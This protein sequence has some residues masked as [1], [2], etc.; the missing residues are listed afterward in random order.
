[1]I[2]VNSRLVAIGLLACPAVVACN[3]KKSSDVSTTPLAASNVA[4]ALGIDA[5]LPPPADPSPASG[6]LKND[7]ATFTTLDDCV[8]N[9]A[10][11]M[12][13]LIGDALLSFGYDTFVRDA[14]RQIDAAK[15]LDSKKC[16][17]IVASDLARHCRAT[18]AEVAGK[19]DDCPFSDSDK[20]DGR[21]PTCVAVASRDPR[22]CVAEASDQESACRA[23]VMG[24]DCD[25]GDKARLASCNRLARR[26]RSSIPPPQSSLPALPKISAKL[27]LTALGGTQSSMPSSATLMN[28]ANSGVAISIGTTETTFS[29]GP[30]HEEAAFP[31]EVTPSSP[32]RIGFEMHVSRSTKSEPKLKKIVLDVPGGVRLDDAQMHAEP[33]IKI[34]ELSNERG[35]AVEFR[36]D[37]EIGTA[38]QAFAFHLEVKTFVRD[39][40][41]AN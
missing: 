22:L 32:L 4:A 27:D 7:I 8:A 39:V 31:H 37:G 10:A 17:A 34:V 25:D 41:R 9:H 2:L 15:S 28:D 40:I 14:C 11:K 12:D 35:G 33:K 13:P 16:D 6:D 38:P 29:F 1:V 21:S 3:A 30:S 20:S 5:D 24:T 23:I 19:P 18:I 26:L 36:I